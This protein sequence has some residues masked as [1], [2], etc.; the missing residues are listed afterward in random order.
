MEKVIGNSGFVTVVISYAQ[1]PMNLDKY[2]VRAFDYTVEPPRKIEV[3]SPSGFGE[4]AVELML[5]LKELPTGVLDYTFY[6]QL[7]KAFSIEES[8]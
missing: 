4:P 5:W 6:E 8:K 2:I 7:G 1:N 3:N